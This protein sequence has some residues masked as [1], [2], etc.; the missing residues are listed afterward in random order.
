MKD[1]LPSSQ[2][3]FELILSTL[4]YADSNALKKRG[5]GTNFHLNGLDLKVSKNVDKDLGYRHDFIGEKP[6]W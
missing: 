6:N 4:G 3:F 1:T 2:S 5:I